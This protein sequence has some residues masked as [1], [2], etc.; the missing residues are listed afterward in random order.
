MEYP[1][2]ELGL[3]CNECYKLKVNREK[4]EDWMEWSDIDSNGFGYTIQP[5]PV[6][7]CDEAAPEECQWCWVKRDEAGDAYLCG[8]CLAYETHCIEEINEM[9]AGPA[10][11]MVTR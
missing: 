2:P 4:F 5:L 9:G 6:P 7:F 1:T 3:T 10:Q 11:K 8:E